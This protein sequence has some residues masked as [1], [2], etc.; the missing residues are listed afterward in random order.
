MDIQP[1]ADEN[2]AFS[3]L[4][5]FFVRMLHKKNINFYLPISLVAKNFDS[6]V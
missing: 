2:A 6:A 3:L 4:I 1:I 5:H